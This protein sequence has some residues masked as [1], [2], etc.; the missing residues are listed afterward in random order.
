[1][2]NNVLCLKPVHQS[3]ALAPNTD[4]DAQT[5]GICHH[6]A[7]I[8]YQTSPF[9]QILQ[10]LRSN[11]TSRCGNNSAPEYFHS[12]LVLLCTSTKYCSFTPLQ[13]YNNTFCRHS[14][15]ENNHQTHSDNTLTI[16]TNF[17]ISYKHIPASIKSIS[18]ISHYAFWCFLR[19]FWWWRLLLLPPPPPL[20]ALITQTP[21]PSLQFVSSSAL[22]NT[23]AKR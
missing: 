17:T 3:N 19:I 11:T 12:S 18:T 14:L 22:E 9:A 13:L 6:L 7:L 10:F 16:L 2:R 15:I 5:W 4:L 23:F 8:W 1:M 20:L 21:T